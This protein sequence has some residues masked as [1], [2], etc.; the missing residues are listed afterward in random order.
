MTSSAIAATK[1]AIHRPPQLTWAVAILVITNIA[2]IAQSFIPLD[3]EDEIPVAA[4]VVSVIISILTFALCWP[5]WNAKY[6]A[7]I[8]TTIVTA[9]NALSGIPGLFD[10]PSGIIV[11]M[12]LAGIPAGLIPIWLIW[13]PRSRQAYAAAA[14][15]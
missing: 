11:A 3:G 15:R 1:P 14:G 12:I 2:F 10:P 8:A 13:H 9:L 4:I 6:W 5:L 7:A